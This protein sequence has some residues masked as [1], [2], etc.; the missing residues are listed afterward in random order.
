MFA[1]GRVLPMQKCMSHPPSSLLNLCASSTD[2]QGG[3]NDEYLSNNE[4]EDLSNSYDWDQSGWTIDAKEGLVFTKKKKGG[5]FIQKDV[6]KRDSLPY[7]T[8]LL[9]DTEGEKKTKNRDKGKDK[10]GSS[11]R[12]IAT[13]YLDAST[14]C[15]DIIALNE[16]AY[17][18]KRVSFVYKF[19]SPKFEVIAKK[20]FCV[21][22]QRHEKLVRNALQ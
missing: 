10:E 1:F 9:L 4:K 6:D 18:V 7:K 20:L 15:G 17:E 14:G 13:L 5:D 16:R 19:R 21:A 11:W 8:Y 22:S 2:N 12:E 3:E